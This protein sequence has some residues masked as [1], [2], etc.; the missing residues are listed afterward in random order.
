MPENTPFPQ[1]RWLHLV[2]DSTRLCLL[3]YGP[4]GYVGL[5]QEAY[6]KPNAGGPPPPEDG[7]DKEWI[8]WFKHASNS[9]QKAIGDINRNLKVLSQYAQSYPPEVPLTAD[10]T[11]EQD[12]AFWAELRSKV[13]DQNID[14]LVSEILIRVA[15]VKRDLKSANLQWPPLGHNDVN[16]ILIEA[17][18]RVAGYISNDGNDADTLTPVKSEV[19][20]PGGN[21]LGWADVVFTQDCEWPQ[22]VTEGNQWRSW[23]VVTNFSL[24]I[25]SNEPL[26]QV[27]AAAAT[28]E[29]SSSSSSSSYYS[30]PTGGM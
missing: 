16:G 15:Q 8:K 7:S 23:G 10:A 1:P 24:K 9:L 22:G 28:L 20:D 12:A 30:T 3:T 19:T 25:T 13:T 18:P 26:S 17:H 14:N 11:P 5:N 29:P 2:N 21:S 6:P 4:K 27:L